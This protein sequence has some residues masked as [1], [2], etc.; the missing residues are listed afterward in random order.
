MPARAEWG[1]GPPLGFAGSGRASSHRGGW[2]GLGGAGLRLTRRLSPQ[3][4][5]DAADLGSC[6][7]APPVNA[8]K[9]RFSG[10]PLLPPL[11]CRH[12]ALGEAG[13]AP[14]PEAARVVF[15]IEERGPSG[16]EELGILR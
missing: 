6:G 7:A 11:A 9:R 15:T 3:R 4:S 8:I 1:R 13:R 5:R 12:G 2:A 10:T 14:E 16:G